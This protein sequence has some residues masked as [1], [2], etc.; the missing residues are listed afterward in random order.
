MTQ[1]SRA[2][3]S[4][5]RSLNELLELARSEERLRGQR[6][7]L[8]DVTERDRVALAATERASEAKSHFLA[9]MSHE[10]RTPLS[11]I[12]GITEMLLDDVREAGH[13]VYSEPLERVHRAGEHL[14][15]LIN[16]ILDIS[17]I[18]AGKMALW[19]QPFEIAPLVRDVVET[20]RPLAE[21]NGN[22]IELACA[23]DLGSLHADPLRVKQ[24]LMNLGSNACKFTKD[25]RVQLRAFREAR[26]GAPAVVF[27][28]TD[29]GLGMSPEQLG[30]LFQEF[31]QADSA[32]LTDDPGT[33]LGLAI[34]Q[35]LSRLMGGDIEA[36]SELGRG[37][38]FVFHLP[39]TAPGESSCDAGSGRSAASPAKHETAE[40]RPRL[41]LIGR[42]E[43]L[44]ALKVALAAKD[45]AV[46]LAPHGGAGL[47]CAHEAVPELALI[48]P[49]LSAPSAW[50]VIAALKSE[51][52]TARVPLVLCAAAGL[53]EV[54]GAERAGGDAYC[55]GGVPEFLRKPLERARLEEALAGVSPMPGGQEALIIDDDEAARVCSRRFLERL[56]WRVSE[57]AD[58]LDGLDW[59]HGTRPGVILLDLDMPRLDG[60]GFLEALRKR[61]DWSRISVI[62][63][64][65]RE[66][67]GPDCLRI[68][69]GI[70]A[71]SRQGPLS[72]REVRDFLCGSLLEPQ[73]P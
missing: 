11:A 23:E 24:V 49:T 27:V 10:L 45:L 61:E 54:A 59:L 35:R 51:A 62:I 70:E 18:E 65:A 53:R 4:R 3:T 17:K 64:S 32:R 1:A 58:G 40:T 42:P 52:R 13:E 5:E 22:V 43:N 34:S 29:T 71:L 47:K 21:K 16:D 8:I 55:L 73:D 46:T 66:I 2:R 6:D 26:L 67:S 30:K 33:G 37:S 63:V 31:M 25:G 39:D 28:V 14:L 44:G 72:T 56:G 48:D 36:E 41:L 9:N 15:L 20:L 19:P 68:S 50:D 7:T 57:A 69:G 12:I 38:R 60:F